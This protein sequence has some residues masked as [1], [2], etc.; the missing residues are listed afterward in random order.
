MSVCPGVAKAKWFANQVCFLQHNKYLYLHRLR[1]VSDNLANKIHPMLSASQKKDDAIIWFEESD[2]FL[3]G[4]TSDIMTI[5]IFAIPKRSLIF[6]F[7]MG[8]VSKRQNRVSDRSPGQK[9]RF[10]LILS[11]VISDRGR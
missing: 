6:F 10:A 4:R 5:I 11:Q 3:L 1:G 9:P 2:L 7:S 8:R